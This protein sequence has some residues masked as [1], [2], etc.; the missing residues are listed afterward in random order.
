[1]RHKHDSCDGA[2]NFSS[3][4]E[5]SGLSFAHLGGLR[6]G[7]LCGALRIA[8]RQA[9]LRRKGSGKTCQP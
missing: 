1:M 4:S 8:Q 9:P 3:V 7:G 6:K 5:A 2:P